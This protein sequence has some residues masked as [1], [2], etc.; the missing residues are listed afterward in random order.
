LA[1]VPRAHGQYSSVYDHAVSGVSK[2]ESTWVRA[3]IAIAG[4]QD[5]H[6]EHDSRQPPAVS[7]RSRRGRQAAVGHPSLNLRFTVTLAG[8][9]RTASWYVLRA[10]RSVAPVQN[11][12]SNS[13]RCDLVAAPLLHVLAIL[14]MMRGQAFPV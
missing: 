11:S 3:A 14:L 13:R 7:R 10:L 5:A 4:V 8:G 6:R 2:F 9:S 12:V 1:I